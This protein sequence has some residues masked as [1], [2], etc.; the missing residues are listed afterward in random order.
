MFPSKSC[1]DVYSEIE[2]HLQVFD[3]DRVV[4]DDFMG[5]AEVD[6]SSY[7]LEIKHQLVLHLGHGD[8]PYLLK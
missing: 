7:E 5:Q 2:I 3:K 4:S 1:R 6:I 8:D